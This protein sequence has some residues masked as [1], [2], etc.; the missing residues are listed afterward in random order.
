MIHARRARSRPTRASTG[1]PALEVFFGPDGLRAGWALALGYLLLEIGD[2]LRQRLVALTHPGPTLTL[3]H[4]VATV[5][6]LGSLRDD[7]SFL[8]ML[9]AVLALLALI[10]R[11]RVSDYNLGGRHA[12]RLALFGALSGAL[13]LSLLVAVL[14]LTHHLA[15]TGRLLFGPDVAYFALAWF[16]AF[17]VV[18]LSEE[19]LLRSFA[20][21]TL[22]RGLT[23][24]LRS[25]DL[26]HSN[27][28]GFWLA[29]LLLSILF[30]ALHG[31][32]PNESP[33][34]LLNVTAAGLLFC[35]ALRR[36][37]SLW[38]A[39]GFHAAWDW[40][41]SFL[42]GVADSGVLTAGRLLRSRALGAPL[43][44][45]GVTGP[46]GSIFALPVLALAALI[47]HLTLPP[48]A[49][50][51]ATVLAHQQNSSLPGRLEP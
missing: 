33:L 42:Y 19:L 27:A 34:G 43:L 50:P 23:G 24:A 44:S 47:V 26:P 15:F 40:A 16:A 13:L 14:A 4:G 6:V 2:D 10:E 5:S 11:R 38:W 41:Q 7:G 31:F 45:G 28:L 8:L 12:L 32:N 20:Q 3:S 46:E 39:I 22:A 25:I 29:A 9:L 36:T 17:L 37:G 30:G 48:R 49:H 21:F 51:G 35:F 1:H 18:A